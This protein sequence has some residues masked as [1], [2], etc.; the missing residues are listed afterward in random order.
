MVNYPEPE[1]KT[2]PRPQDEQVQ[3]LKAGVWELAS[4][5]ISIIQPANMIRNERR[6]K[7]VEKRKKTPAR[8]CGLLFDV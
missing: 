4:G 1:I 3:S 2:F 7:I 6:R 8:D 5:K